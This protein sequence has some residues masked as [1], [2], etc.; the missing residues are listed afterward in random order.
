M[1]TGT[2]P[3]GAAPEPSPL[4]TKILDPQLAGCDLCVGI[5][6]VSLELT[7]QFYRPDSMLIKE[8]LSETVA[9]L[10][11]TD[12]NVSGTAIVTFSR[13]RWQRMNVRHAMTERVAKNAH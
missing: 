2:P 3:G 5:C 4:L 10:Q 1:E 8:C 13:T 6:M 7:V 9:V 12:I 11:T